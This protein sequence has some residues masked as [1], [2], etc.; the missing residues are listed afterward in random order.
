MTL[1]EEYVVRMVGIVKTFPGVVANKS[2][3]LEVKRGEIHGLLGEN[4]AGKTTLM[5]ILSGY[6]RPDEGQIYIDGKQVKMRSPKDALKLGI[7]M[8]Y[9]HFTLIPEFKVVE[10]VLL[11]LDVTRRKLNLKSTAALIEEHAKRLGFT[12]DPWSKVADLSMGE[13][14]RV[15]ILKVLLRGARVL[16][17][18]EPT[19]VLAPV[20]VS[21]LF[22]ILR[23]L[24]SE[25]KSIVFITHKLNE[26][27]EIC[28]RITVLRSGMKI[29]T[30]SGDE[31]ESMVDIVRMMFGIEAEPALAAE[32][33]RQLGREVVRVENLV[34]QSDKGL[35]AVKDVSFTIRGGEI[36]GLAGIDGN[37]QKELAE[38]LAG[39][40]STK[41][42]GI[43]LNGTDVTGLGAEALH[44]KGVSYITDDRIGE[45]LVQDFTLAENLV[46]KDFRRKDF[47]GSV[48]IDW[49]K[50]VEKSKAIIGEYELAAPSPKTLTQT[51]SGGTQ[52]RLLVGREIGR[53]A[54]FIIANQPTHGVDAKTTLYIRKKLIE[55]AARGAAVL[56]ISNDLDEIFS[57]CH[58][59]A[60]IYEG[61]VL[62]ILDRQTATRE[63]VAYLMIGVK[64]T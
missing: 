1:Q 56:L 63:D 21:G 29:G 43:Y 33:P 11:G 58:T 23:Q 18:D 62:G 3:D 2:I 37:G 46:L 53:E 19:S 49:R 57:C 40:R 61:R 54:A 51:L 14:Q 20:E 59:I 25:G 5:N 31:V 4:G 64:H 28:D 60:V 50:V 55:E 30:V 9:Q 52:Q 15:E 47:K 10:N 39:I 12:I 27:M 8:V 41:S 42:G 35:D 22:S 45:G 48:F 38:A 32:L 24:A 13:Q 16:I 44:E 34:V 17:L 6:Y 36:L 26:A 7:G